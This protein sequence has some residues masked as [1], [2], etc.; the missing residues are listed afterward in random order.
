MPA[1]EKDSDSD[2][3]KK[4]SREK[5][6]NN[7]YFSLKDCVDYL[8]IIHEIGGK[9]EA[10]VESILSKLEVTSIH[11]RRFTYLTSSA[12]NFS[13]IE[14]TNVGIKRTKI[15]TLILYPPSGEEQRKKLLIDAF[16]SPLL[17]QKILERYNNMIL[18]NKEILKNIFYSLGIAR[19]VLDN[20]VN[21]F[22]ESAQYAN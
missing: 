7:P 12:E 22:I 1:N 8:S 11:N 20:A 2:M 5:S 19:I 6:V 13:L 16:K 9:K 18:P 14:K 10:P 15:G 3:L 4:K 17:Y 21:S